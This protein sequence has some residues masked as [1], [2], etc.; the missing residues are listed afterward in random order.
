MRS[1]S[2]RRIIPGLLSIVAVAAFIVNTSSERCGLLFDSFHRTLIDSLTPETIARLEAESGIG[3]ADI[4]RM[5]QANLGRALDKLRLPDA[6][7]PD[8]AKALRR[9]QQLSSNKQFNTKNWLKAHEQVKTMRTQIVATAGLDSTNWESIGPGN[10]GGRIR[11]LAFD[12]D[13]SNRIYA[14]GVT[15]GVWLSENGG[16][17]WTATDD[18]M[19][20]LAVATI[21]FDPTNSNILYV[22]TGERVRGNGIFKS[23]DKGANWSVLEST[24]ENFN[25]YYVRR[26]TMLNDSTRL[27]AATTTGIWISDDDGSSWTQAHGGQAMDVDVHPF[28]NDKLVAGTYGDALY[29]LDGGQSW[30]TAS[31]LE[32]VGGR[33]EIAYAKSNPDIVYAS[34]DNNSGEIWK[35]IDGGQ[36]YSLVNTGDEYMYFQG[37]YDNTLWV[38]PTDATHIIAG[39]I[40]LVRSTDGGVTLDRSL[41]FVHADQHFII[42]HPAYDGVTNRRVYFTNDGG[43]DTVQDIYLAGNNVGWQDLN[44][45]LSVTQ[46]YGIAVAPDGTVV[47]GTQ[48]NGTLIY[49]GDS[50]GWT[51]T[52]GGDGGFSAA[53]PTD[54][55]YIYGGTQNGWIHRSTNGGFGSTYIS[56]AAVAAGA[57]FIAPFILDPNNENRLLAGSRELWL[58]D[59][60]KAVTPSWVS[61]KAATPNMTP[62]SAIAVTPGVSDVIYVGH[63]DGSIYKTMDGTSSTPTWFEMSSGQLPQR[64]L[65]RIAID[66][67]NTDTVYVAFGGYDSDNLWRSVD[68]GNSWNLAVGTPPASIP[69]APIRTIAIHPAESSQLYVGTEIG[70]FGSADAGASWSISNDGPANVSIDELVWHGTQTLFAGTHGRGVFRATV[71]DVVA[72]GNQPP[73]LGPIGDQIVAEDRQLVIPLAANDPDG[74]TIAFSD[75]GLPGFCDPLNDNGNGTGS[76]VCNPIP[77]NQG[78]YRFSVTVSDNGTPVLNDGEVFNIRV[79]QS[80][81]STFVLSQVF[82]GS[83]TP[84]ALDGNMALI[85]AQVDTHSASALDIRNGSLLQ[86]FANPNPG[87]SGWGSSE[88]WG[89]DGWGQIVALSAGR[90]LISAESEDLAATDSGAAYLFDANSGDLLHTFTHPNPDCN[91]RC[92]GGIGQTLGHSIALHGDNALIATSFLNGIFLFDAVTGALLHSFPEAARVDDGS[93]DMSDQFIVIGNT[94]MSI[95]SAPSAGVVRLYDADTRSILRTLFNPTPSDYDVFGTA[96]AIDG[97]RV[98]IGAKGVDIGGVTNAGEAYL[99]DATTGLLVHTFVDPTPNENAY[100]GNHLDIAGDL[101]AISSEGDNEVH[102]FDATS[103]VRVQTLSEVP[104][105]DHGWFGTS[106]DLEPGHLL[107]GQL[108]LS[109][110]AYLY[111]LRRFLDIPPDYWAFSFIERLAENGITAGCGGNNFCPQSPVTRAQMAVFL[112]RGMNGSGFSPPAATGTVFLDVETGDFAASFIEKLASDGIT[113]GCGNN[114]Y[115]PDAEVTRAQMAVFLLRA[116]H[117]S[118]YSPPP[119]TGVFSD[120]P[121]SYW[122]SRWIEQLAAEGITAGCGNNNYCPEAIVTRDQMAVFLV[123][124]FGL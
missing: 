10:I 68:G 25:F 84:V 7:N 46:F 16:Q 27:V 73:V 86:S 102:V 47:G 96:V 20:N 66:P 117:G 121:M 5:P 87:T 39:G 61:I 104:E 101:V 116:K 74:D 52:Y 91:E 33:V 32:S 6:T 78:D 24:R 120:V 15:G 75:S 55:D 51:A 58:S 19:D 76:I 45:G 123:R 56:D 53:D 11:S 85:G 22:G 26:L 122:A 49:K 110:R 67:L 44:N 1:I 88:G 72:G 40:V 43:V 92:I 109:G 38:D 93:L 119:A 60:V 59:D 107:V 70:V 80:A 8:A 114:N 36:S 3:V 111:R 18:F 50:E 89:S 118:G 63:N 13:N 94:V 54:S 2:A 57:N 112:E 28:D 64:Y 9:L 103:G 95:G 42:E 100:F 108:G 115:C 98:L 29:S 82:F 12:P 124:T 113:A 65:M 106:V 83:G 81:A 31:G 105:R 90:V 62:I 17:S 97:N 69:P 14:G 4:C 35:S 71:S 30:D 21:I 37:G 34:I 79:I 41:T 23:T 77:G 48:D 99:F